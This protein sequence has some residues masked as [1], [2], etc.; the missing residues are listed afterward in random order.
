MPSSTSPQDEPRRP[1]PLLRVPQPPVDAA[2][3]PRAL[4]RVSALLNTA[5]STCPN[6][7]MPPPRSSTAVK[8]MLE[9]LPSWMRLRDLMS[10][11]VGVTPTGD[12]VAPLALAV[13]IHRFS[14]PEMVT[15]CAMATPGTARAPAT[16][17]ARSFFCIRIPLCCHWRRLRAAPETLVLLGLWHFPQLGLAGAIK[18][19]L[20]RPCSTRLLQLRNKSAI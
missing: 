13:S 9:P 10:Y 20:E 2:A 19:R 17:T 4:A 8:R 5:D 12:C 14:A 16:A 11:V 6:A 15:D 7:C 1:T 3:P 18:S